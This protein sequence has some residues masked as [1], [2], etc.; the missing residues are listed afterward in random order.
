MSEAADVDLVW[1]RDV[2]AVLEPAAGRALGTRNDD[3][4]DAR[5]AVRS[6]AGILAAPGPQEKA[7]GL[8]ALVTPVTPVPLAHRPR[9]QAGGGDALM[10]SAARRR[11]APHFPTPRSV[12]ERS[13][14]R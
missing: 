13:E 2:I 6:P 12:R 10:A 1:L 7:G 11:R 9:E 14:C 3:A 5:C 4:E 8:E